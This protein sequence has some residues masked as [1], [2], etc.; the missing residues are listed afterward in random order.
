MVVVLTYMF[1][2]FFY[3]AFKSWDELTVLT[4]DSQIKIIV[5]VSNCD[6]SSSIYAHSNWIVCDSW[7]A[8]DLLENCILLAI[9]AH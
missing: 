2:K 1:I 3:L 5:V 9:S 4:E 7:N 8:T 6:L